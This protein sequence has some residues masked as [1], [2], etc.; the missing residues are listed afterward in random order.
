MSIIAIGLCL[1]TGIILLLVFIIIIVVV[2]ETK[3]THAQNKPTPNRQHPNKTGRPVLSL[4]ER[5]TQ[6]FSS[7]MKVRS[8]LLCES[9]C[10][11]RT[12]KLVLS[13]KE[14]AVRFRPSRCGFFYLLNGVFLPGGGGASPPPPRSP[15]PPRALLGARI[16]TLFSFMG[17]RYGSHAVYGA[18]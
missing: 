12:T 16:Q 18:M 1:I 5:L 6:Q 13:S 4:C 3:T 8:I 2:N 17:I 7:R 10:G 15:T 9:P 14:L 11:T